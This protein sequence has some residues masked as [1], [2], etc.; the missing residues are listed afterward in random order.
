M[1]LRL[2]THK[3]IRMQNYI[4][5]ATFLLVWITS[6][7]CDD[8]MTPDTG[9]ILPEKKYP[10]EYSELYSGFMGLAASMQQV[11]DQA[12]FLEGLRGDLLEP[13]DNAPR[14][15]WDVYR[16][17]DLSGNTLADPVGYY[18][19][20]LNAN[21]YLQH[22]F[23]YKKAKPDVIA[24][25]EYQGLIAGA[26]RYKVW[27][28]LMLARIY[29]EAI[30]F[31]ETLTEFQDLGKYPVLNYDQLVSQC[32]SLMENGLNGYNGIPE[33]RWST[34][35]FPGQADSPTNLMWN[36][37]CPPSE[38]LLAEIYLNQYEYQKAWD[39]CVAIIK[40]GGEN[41]ASYQL[42]LSEYNGEWKTFSYN[43]VRK[44]QITVAFF[45]FSLKQTNRYIQYYSNNFPNK[46][47][48][49]P[50]VAN[51]SR[52]EN[53]Y[54]AGGIKNDQYRGS[55]VTYKQVNGNWVLQKFLAGHE[56]S[57]KIHTN[58]VQ[59]TLYRAAEVHLF[60]IEAL[61]G[62]GRFEEALAFLNNGVGSYYNASAGKFNSP[63]EPYPSCLYRTS[64]TSE[65]ANRG[66]R[67][68]VNLGEVGGFSLQSASALDTLIAMRRLDSLLV[69]EISLELAGEGKA[70][71]AMNRM[72]RKWSNEAP[73]NWAQ[74][75]I[76]AS[77]GGNPDG[78]WG[79]EVQQYW[80]KTVAAKYTDG[81]AIES[82]LA[83]DKKNWFITID[84]KNR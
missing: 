54:N 16:Y 49:R 46:Y 81:L 37:I 76:D 55:G 28:Y 51:R 56:T 44:E 58:D 70:L 43:F 29:G 71:Y 8:F 30:W 68:R 11:A 67:G 13:T 15:V 34:V 18:N 20:I 60:M 4:K 26:I 17:N 12:S 2:L 59:I 22:L 79:N 31:D 21:D 41:E 14:E 61:V 19:L 82:K 1:R 33:I 75:W 3:K 63:F 77:G 23:A 6:V 40:R 80:A 10:G 72:L 50:T 24:E 7:S 48:L 74:R 36:R 35:L 45:D 25:T 84:L 5:I 53:Q 83:A 62:M 47:Y 27:A 78:L 42:N 52:F 57:D 66:V 32:R 9:E 65:L 39:Q 64:S 69:E 73:R 38:V